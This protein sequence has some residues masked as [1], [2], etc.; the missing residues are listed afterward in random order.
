MGSGNAEV[1]RLGQ[2]SDDG[3]QRTEDREQKTDLS[4]AVGQ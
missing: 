1:G 3:G 4:S 2:R